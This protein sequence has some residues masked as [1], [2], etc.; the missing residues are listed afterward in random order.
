MSNVNTTRIDTAYPVPGVNNSTQGFRDNFTAIKNNLD[1]VKS[2]LTDLQLK[3]ITKYALVGGTLA[4]DMNGNEIS[5]VKTRGSRASTYHLGSNLGGND[6]VTIDVN[7]ADVHYGTLNGDIILDFIKWSPENT[8]SEVTLKFLVADPT[9]TIRFPDSDVATSGYITSGMLRSIRS[10][11]NYYAVQQDETLT[12]PHAHTEPYTY[13]NYI[14]VPF[15][16]T[17]LNLKVYTDDCGT[18][19]EVMPINRPYKS[20][21]LEIRIP[22]AVGQPGD[23]PGRVCVGSN[24][25]YVCTGIYDGSTTIWQKINIDGDVV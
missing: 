2:E 10:L 13:Q 12:Y 25:L 20:S 19:L 18:T 1:T 7:R 16:V 15:N 17:E 14:S 22:T 3:A 4:N 24:F 23:F 11:E 21:Q 5:N 8:R 9:A 6:T